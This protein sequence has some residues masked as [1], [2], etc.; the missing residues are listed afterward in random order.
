MT[1]RQLHLNVNILTSGFYASAWRT[2]NIDP[3]SFADIKHYIRVAQIAERGKFDAVFLADQP[4]LN[5]RLEYGPTLALE[6]TIVLTAV[7]AATEHI[8]LIATA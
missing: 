7:A 4:A 6:P 8:G 2:K 3:F 1:N 5:G